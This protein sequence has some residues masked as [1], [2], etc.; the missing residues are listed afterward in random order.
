MES[1]EYHVR[2][3]RCVEGVFAQN[4]IQMYRHPFL[5]GGK[6]L[7]ATIQHYIYL[8]HDS[9]RAVTFQSTVLGW[10]DWLKIFFIHNRSSSIGYLLF[11]W[12]SLSVRP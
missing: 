11:V 12:F 4:E 9:A 10:D 6:E 2:E 3:V 8:H 5:E 7:G 1:F